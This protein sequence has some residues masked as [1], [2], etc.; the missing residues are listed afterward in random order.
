MITIV[1]VS[2]KKGGES[3][4]RLPPDGR[5]RSRVVLCAYPRNRAQRVED[6]PQRYSTLEKAISAPGEFREFLNK[7]QVHSLPASW[8]VIS[9]FS[10]VRDRKGG[11]VSGMV[12]WN[13]PPKTAHM[14]DLDP[15]RREIE[16]LTVRTYEDDTRVAA[17]LYVLL[18]RRID[19]LREEFHRNIHSEAY[20]IISSC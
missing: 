7:P 13:L 16:R 9:S 8:F 18:L 14:R 5:Q 12:K 20:L 11:L 17:Q 6:R 4:S 15:S 1:V 19:Y 10:E 2:T 3:G